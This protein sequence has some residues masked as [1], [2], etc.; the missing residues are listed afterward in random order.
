MEDLA[1]TDLAYKVIEA[2][3]DRPYVFIC[4]RQSR[5]RSREILQVQIL[6]IR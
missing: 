2:R 1:C 6:P 4:R 5:Q 3:S